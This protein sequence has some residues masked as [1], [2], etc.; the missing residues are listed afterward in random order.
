MS[1]RSPFTSSVQRVR[2][3]TQP[4]E[5]PRHPSS[6]DTHSEPIW[7]ITLEHGISPDHHS[8]DSKIIL[9]DTHL[10][11]RNKPKCQVCIPLHCCKHSYDKQSAWTF[12]SVMHIDGKV[13]D[14]LPVSHHLQ[15]AWAHQPLQCC[16]G[17]RC[18][19][20]RIHISLGH[21]ATRFGYKDNA[22]HA[23]CQCVMYV[24]EI[25]AF[26]IGY[27]QLPDSLVGELGRLHLLLEISRH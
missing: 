24:T 17:K 3:K 5:H 19:A 12:Q 7:V 26:S 27:R 18:E 21:S 22:E 25:Q 23:P 13:E 9:S 6:T 2:G 14:V 4:C 1:S 11:S 16:W 20:G 15:A 8:M 10:M